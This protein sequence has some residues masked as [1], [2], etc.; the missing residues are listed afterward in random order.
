MTFFEY[1]LELLF[2]P[3]IRRRG[4]GQSNWP[5]PNC[6]HESFHSLPT[7]PGKKDRT[8][9]HRCAFGGDIHDMMVQCKV[10]G[11]YPDR[12][13]LIAEWW[14][15]YEALIPPGTTGSQSHEPINP[16]TGKPYRTVETRAV[17]R[18]W[19]HLTKA[20]RD[21]LFRVWE[22]R[23]QR[24]PQV[25]LDVVADSEKAMRDHIARPEPTP[26]RPTANR[27]TKRPKG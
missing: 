2:G 11:R 26:S 25:S 16:Y 14:R 4:D 20:E 7:K 6:G 3:P 17:E 5:C 19:A 9:C 27:T 23:E 24:F 10:G 12:E 15:D 1:E 21:L 18:A 13:A 22:L 8:R